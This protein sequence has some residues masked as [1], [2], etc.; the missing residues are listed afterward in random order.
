MLPHSVCKVLLNIRQAVAP[1]QLLNITG[2][3]MQILM[4]YF[5]CDVVLDMVRCR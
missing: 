4:W 5:W 2:D 1:Y 3:Q